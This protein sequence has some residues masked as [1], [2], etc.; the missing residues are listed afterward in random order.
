MEEA[1][2]FQP[3]K[4]ETSKSKYKPFTFYVHGITKDDKRV[5]C[6]IKNFYS[7]VYVELKTSKT[8]ALHIV[9]KF[10][11]DKQK[12]EHDTDIDNTNMSLVYR[13]KLYYMRNSYFM[14]VP[15]RTVS[16]LYWIKEY[17]RH[18]V[19]AQSKKVETRIHEDKA[20]PE[21]KLFAKYKIQPSQ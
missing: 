19:K 4:W 21:M 9:D 17:F 6:R 1:I 10:I 14:Y 15:Y 3:Y 18:G 13:K 5:C 12:S 8:D 16:A 11:S 7:Y 2:L 20:T